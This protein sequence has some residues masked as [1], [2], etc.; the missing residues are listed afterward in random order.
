MRR[1]LRGLSGRRFFTVRSRDVEPV[2]EEIQQQQRTDAAATFGPTTGGHNVRRD[3]NA[4]LA[5]NFQRLDERDALS[6]KSVDLFAIS[7]ALRLTH[8]PDLL[9]FGS[10]RLLDVMCLALA[11][12]FALLGA[13]ARDLDTDSRRHKILLV[14]SLRLRLLELNA[15][16]FRFAL[17]VVHVLTLLGEDFF[18]LRLHQFFRQM[19]VADEHVHHVD[20][21]LEQVRAYA[22]LSAFLLFVPVLQVSHRGRLRRLITKDRVD[23]RMHYVL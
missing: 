20:V 19:N 18:R 9:G 14:V 3:A 11:L 17:S 8:Q 22:S 2:A 16:L 7:D 23:Q 15:L 12:S 6:P 4:L 5:D 21:I 1:P 10:A 13:F